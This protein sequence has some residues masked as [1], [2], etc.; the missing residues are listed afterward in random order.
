MKTDL[1]ASYTG[2]PESSANEFNRIRN[3]VLLLTD[4]G[5]SP[6]T[7]LVASSEHGEGATTIAT[8]LS[9]GLAE[10][11]GAKPLR[12]DFNF[13]SADRKSSESRSKGLADWLFD[14]FKEEYIREDRRAPGCSVLDGGKVDCHPSR[15]IESSDFQPYMDKLKEMFNFVVIDAPPLQPYPETTLLASRVDGVILVVRAEGPRREVVMDA[16]KKLHEVHAN[17]YGVVLNQRKHY[18]PGWIY[19]RI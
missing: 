17:I 8:H 18:I 12:L 14:G 13:R 6:K 7:V 5:R 15:I 19:R 2:L 9:R 1:S 3:A 16:V 4:Y 10:H 11:P